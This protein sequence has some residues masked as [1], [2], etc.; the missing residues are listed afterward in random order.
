MSFQ[1]IAIV[2]RACVLP[3]ALTPAALWENVRAGRDLISPAPAGRWRRSPERALGA[4]PDRASTD[5]GGYVTGFAFDPAGFAIAPE[6]L[7]SLD[8]QTQWLLHVSREGLREAR[9][10]GSRRVGAVFG[11]LSFPTAS[12]ARFAERTWLG[13]ALADELEIPRADARS[14][15]SSG[16][17]AHLVA[18]ALGLGEAFCLDAACASSLYAI[19]IACDRLHDGSVD[20]M[21]AGAVTC[22]DDLFIH[23]GFTALQ[24][25]SPSGRSRPFHHDADGLVPAEGAG[26][27]V[28]KRLSDALAAKDR[29]FGVIRGVGLSNDGRGSGLIAPSEEGQVRAMRAAY[30]EAGLSPA[31]V[32]LVECHA[33]GTSVG[34]RTEIRSLRRVFEG[35]SGLPIGSLK[36]NF[37]HAVAV[38]GVAGLLKVLGAIEA[39]ER[40]PT[41]HAEQ[42][43][44][45]LARS[46]L[47][48]LEK[49]EPWPS[50]GPRRAA[51]SAFGFGGCNAHLVVEEF[52]AKAKPRAAV[53]TAEPGVELAIVGMGT[54]VGDGCT[55]GDFAKALGEQKPELRNRARALTLEV[56]ATRFPP[57]DLEQALPQ[58][59]WLLAAARE[60]LT[61]LELPKRERLGVYV[62]MGCDPE[63]ARFG[64][65]WRSRDWAQALAIPDA[66]WAK[67]LEDTFIGPLEAAG[68]LGTLPNLPANR[69]N[70][71]F[72]LA[73][74][75][76]TVSAEE[77]S[78]LRALQVAASALRR[79]EID[80]ALVGASDFTSQVHEAAC[81]AL[82]INAP[83]GD[84]AVALAVMRAADAR[85]EKRP[86]FALLGFE[87]GGKDFDPAVVE[88]RFGRAHAAFGLV[89][90][91][92]AAV[93]CSRGSAKHLRVSVEALG[94]QRGTVCLHAP[95]PGAVPPGAV[96][97][98][99]V[100]PGAEAPR[101]SVESPLKGTSA[102]VSYPAHRPDPTVPALPSSDDPWVGVRPLVPTAPQKMAPAP[103]L[104]SV[105]EVTDELPAVVTRSTQSTAST[106]ST[107][108][109][110]FHSPV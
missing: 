44:E 110:T 93:E 87:D 82:G 73:G 30:D 70:F 42:P 78:G 32:S 4:G 81:R 12:S 38:A 34:D 51:V 66:S 64:A 75:G 71:Q 26:V 41:L 88:A 108:P 8:P 107:P 100:P 22:C 94:G 60:A 50:D 13:E 48:L 25:L 95:P 83:A 11:N 99:A 29:V 61:G 2:G 89:Q 69:L 52:E 20:A 23:T 91:A 6:E 43:L 35:A 62:G 27:V 67:R 65:R 84:G 98:G 105:L 45:D 59:T 102:S 3:G 68:V 109:G 77:L 49:A 47:R 33:T 39:R 86:V 79:G 18:R 92:A 101:L 16:L 57:R 76:L 53:R 37:G 1:P 7:A 17:P 15:F 14:R 85:R 24:A 80:L 58:Q 31:D 10:E 104:P 28:L 36:S 54:A 56:S 90:V 106:Q 5:R 46:P 74:P 72:D 40:P 96:P 9:L 55:L 19:K 97:P 63:I 21:L 103:A